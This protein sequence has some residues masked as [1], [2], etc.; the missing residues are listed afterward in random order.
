MVPFPSQVAE[1]LYYREQTLLEFTAEVIEVRELARVE[2]RPVFQV[3]LDCTAFYPTGGG[4]PH[5]VGSLFATARSGVVLEAPI[6][7]VEED[8]SGEIWHT[9]AKPLQ[10]GTAVRGRV[11]A[12]RRR[13][14]MQQ[15]S[16]QHLL[17]AI[18]RRGMGAETV[19][20]HLGEKVSTIDLA[21]ALTEQQME[22][23]ERLG[24]EAIRSALPVTQRTV[25]GQ[26]AE[27]MLASGVLRKLPP[28]TGDLRLIEIGDIDLNACG[29]THVGNTAEIGPLLLRGTERKRGNTRLM[30]LCGSRALAA[31]REDWKVLSSIAHAL[32]TGPAQVAERV[33][34]MQA[35]IK[36]LR[37]QVAREVEGD[38]GGS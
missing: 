18:L 27:Q 33:V 14:H 16:G 8:G 31:A 10:Q 3:A 12:E 32:S 35:E 20:F 17:S 4:Q 24:N 9:T 30:F 5:D 29:G 7:G 19:S 6:T 36:R 2:G 22:D 23:A 28:R 38:T 11:D 34:Q 21:L 37:K 15:H 1:R 25:T 26:E 13:D